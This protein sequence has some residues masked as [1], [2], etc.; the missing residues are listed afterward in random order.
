[1]NAVYVVASEHHRSPGKRDE[2]LMCVTL[3]MKHCTTCCSRSALTT[4]PKLSTHM[5]Q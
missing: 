1:M 2:G 3:L 5:A 4:N